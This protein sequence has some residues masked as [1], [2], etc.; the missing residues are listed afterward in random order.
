MKSCRIKEI[1][2]ADESVKFRIEVL[3][4][5][6]HWVHITD[7]DTIEE[8]RQVKEQIIGSSVVEERIVE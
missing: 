6:G 5:R 2:Y 4:P 3:T 7:R 8:A 1:T